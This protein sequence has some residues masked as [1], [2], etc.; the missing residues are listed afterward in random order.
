MKTIKFKDSNMRTSDLIQILNDY[1]N[2]YGD[3]EV[4][5][6]TAIKTSDGGIM[7]ALTHPNCLKVVEM[8]DGI[9]FALQGHF[10]YY[11]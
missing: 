7:P 4:L 11:I 9:Y 6:E 1:V 5:I 8:K 3:K 10:C 2:E